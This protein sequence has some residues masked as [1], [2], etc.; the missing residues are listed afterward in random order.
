MGSTAAM[1]RSRPTGCA[2]SR[3]TCISARNAPQTVA[4]GFGQAHLLWSPQR[5]NVACQ[6]GL[7][8]WPPSRPADVQPTDRELAHRHQGTFSKAENAPPIYAGP[9]AVD[10][11][12]SPPPSFPLGWN[13]GRRER[14]LP[15]LVVRT[16]LAA[17]F[18]R[19]VHPKNG[20][21]FFARQKFLFPG[22]PLPAGHSAKTTAPSAKAPQPLRAHHALASDY[23]QCA[24][25]LCATVSH[26]CG[27][28]WAA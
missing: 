18:L 13:V 12:A 25:S 26:L 9:L 7:P 23:A 6:P 14:T 28:R 10:D 11:R 24:H 16:S 17:N 19:G 4:R 15:H 1:A 21:R 22:S 8:P 3:D 2:T 5:L 20:C 27:C